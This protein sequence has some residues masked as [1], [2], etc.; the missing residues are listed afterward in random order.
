VALV[1]AHRERV[2]RRL[3]APL[4][5]VLGAP[6]AEVLVELPAEVLVVLLAEVPEARLVLEEQREPEVLLA[7]ELLLQ[8]LQ[9]PL[10]VRFLP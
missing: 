8:V 5:E 2:E 1:V 4:A 10:R 3:G 9:V 6:L 7:P